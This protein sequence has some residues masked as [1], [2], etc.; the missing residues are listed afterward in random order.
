M[1]AETPRPA[2]LP[3]YAQKVRALKTIKNKIGDRW[4][5]RCLMVAE[6]AQSRVR[7]SSPGTK[8]SNEK[9][10]LYNS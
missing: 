10:N 9:S 3:G 4:R 7:F 6:G 5:M 2:I 8:E 1:L